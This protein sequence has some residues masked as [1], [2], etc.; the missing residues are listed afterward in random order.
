MLKSLILSWIL[1]Q[2]GSWIYKWGI[3]GLAI[4]LIFILACVVGIIFIIKVLDNKCKKNGNTNNAKGKKDGIIIP[5]KNTK[6]IITCI[7]V[8]V[9]IL[10]ILIGSVFALSN[11]I[12]F[13]YELTGSLGIYTERY[14][15]DDNNTWK[16]E[17]TAL[18]NGTLKKVINK[19]QE[20]LQTLYIDNK[21]E[22]GTLSLVVNQGD[23]EIE[24]L[25]DNKS[26][27]EIS[28]EEFSSDSIRLAVEHNA[29]DNIN[30]LVE[31][32]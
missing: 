2:N 4:K 12:D 16:V 25:I 21:T 15:S 11:K 18:T 9:I 28:L 7:S 26:K 1:F 29:A 17:C 24:Y 32:K 23:K 19:Q 13:F 22:E 27:M 31:W 10:T 8:P 20:K 5:K 3:W 6:I 14:E 30:F